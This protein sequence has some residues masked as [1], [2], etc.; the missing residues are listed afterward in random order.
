VCLSPPLAHESLFHSLNNPT[1][2]LDCM[3]TLGQWLC[4]WSHSHSLQKSEV[5]SLSF[6]SLSH[7]PTTTTNNTPN[8]S[9]SPKL[10]TLSFSLTITLYHRDSYHMS[11]KQT[12][13]HQYHHFIIF[14]KLYFEQNNNNFKSTLFLTYRIACMPILERKSYCLCLRKLP[15]NTP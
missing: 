12:L 13:K 8:S 2:H 3:W 15:I 9:N 7:V 5:N 14:P 11:L 1:P 4:N 6:L 10:K